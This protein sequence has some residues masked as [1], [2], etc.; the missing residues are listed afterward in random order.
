MKYDHFGHSNSIYYI[1]R[2]LFLPV[3]LHQYIFIYDVFKILVN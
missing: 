3:F 1:S 2:I